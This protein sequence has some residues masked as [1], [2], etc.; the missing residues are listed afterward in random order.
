MLNPIWSGLFGGGSALGGG[1][2]TANNSKTIN[3]NEMKSGGLQ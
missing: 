2:P 1:V 3:D